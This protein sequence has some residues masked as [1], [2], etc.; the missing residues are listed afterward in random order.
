VVLV[1]AESS[2]PTV[3]S[4]IRWDPVGHAEAELAARTEVGLPPSVHMAAVDGTAGAV[5]ALLEEARLPEG[6][7]VLGPVDLPPGVRRPAGTPADVPATRMLVRVRR[8]QGLALAAALRRGVGLLS[9]R[10][11]HEPVRVQ[12]DPLHIG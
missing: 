6:A 7:D 2:V 5:T 12:I 4:L 8:E 3:Q 11:S 1:V 10:Q 9:A